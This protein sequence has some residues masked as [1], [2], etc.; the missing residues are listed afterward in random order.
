M[1]PPDR[2]RPVGEQVREIEPRQSRYE[3]I[4]EPDGIETR[5]A[6]DIEIDAIDIETVVV[7]TAIGLVEIIYLERITA[8]VAIEQVGIEIVAHAREATENTIVALAAVNL[9]LAACTNQPI[10][11]FKAIDRVR[12]RGSDQ[13]FAACRAVDHRHPPSPDRFCARVNTLCGLNKS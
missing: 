2:N 4:I 13:R 12:T 5:P 7:G 10:I 3:A 1:P 11:A 8:F 6:I 9:I